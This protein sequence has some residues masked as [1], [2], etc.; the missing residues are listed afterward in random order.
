M[1]ATL[2]APSLASPPSQATDLY[3]YSPQRADPFPDEQFVNVPNIPVFAEHSTTTKDGRQLKFGY[4][5]LKAVADRCNRRIQETGD[6]AALALGHNPDPHAKAMGASDPKPMGYA[7]PFRMGE[8]VGLDGTK[9]Y[10][11]LADLHYFKD[12]YQEAR[13]YGRRSAELWVEDRYEE[14]FLDP[15]ALLGSQTPRLDLGL[16]YSKH[17]EGR[18]I[19]KYAAVFPGATSVHVMDQQK[20]HAAEDEGMDNSSNYDPALVKAIV[21]AL[22][23]LPQWQ[24]LE[25]MIAAGNAEGDPATDSVGD[26]TGG[27]VPPAQAGGMPEMPGMPPAQ[28]A[29]PPAPLAAPPAAPAMQ[30]PPQ[31]SPGDS[32]G[33]P[34]DA[35][36][37]DPG[38]DAPGGDQP[39]DNPEKEKDMAYQK[40]CYAALDAMDDDELQQ[41]MAGRKKKNYEAEEGTVGDDQPE[42]EAGS[43][44]QSPG[45]AEGISAE[46]EKTISE[47]GADKP[48]SST[49]YSRGSK[50]QSEKYQL[51]SL[52]TRVATLEKE[53]ETERQ[54]RIDAERRGRLEFLRH[55]GFTIDVDRA[56]NLLNYARCPDSK[57]FDEQ[58]EFMAESVHRA[59]IGH[60]LPNV[61]G[62]ERFE[63]HRPGFKEDD[64]AEHYSKQDQEHAWSAVRRRINSAAKD[65]PDTSGWFEEELDRARA[66]RV[67]GSA[68]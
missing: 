61:P 16:S 50:Q 9:K 22:M 34:M 7:G 35:A 10:A 25:A 44:S 18:V 19:E 59:P 32:K 56:M 6:Y 67:N 40:A 63:S 14:M 39:Q 54:L 24:Q 15:I 26:A 62:A 38:L 5:E 1:P 55:Q 58:V 42:A 3:A 60:S 28:P 64:K 4:A 33:P 53:R 36:G 31:A 29:A 45:Q 57:H 23:Q 21:D 47:Q 46:G 49:S 13:K 27:Q 66:S 8:I 48:T 52:R 65:N 20:P 68:A 30:E 2:T 11:I 51:D 17:H 43:Y 41:Y 37:G 12:D